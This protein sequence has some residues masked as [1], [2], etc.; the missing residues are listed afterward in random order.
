M[1]CRMYITTD[2]LKHIKTHIEISGSTVIYLRQNGK[3][4]NHHPLD[5]LCCD[6]TKVVHKCVMYIY[7]L[8]QMQ[9]FRTENSTR[10]TAVTYDVT[11]A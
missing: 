7:Y 11:P 9:P 3:Y 8:G 2:G 10:A 6:L 1:R 5:A 4:T